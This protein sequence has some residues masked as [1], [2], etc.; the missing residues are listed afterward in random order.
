LTVFLLAPSSKDIFKF[1]YFKPTKEQIEESSKIDSIIRSK[2]AENSF[3]TFSR[4]SFGLSTQSAPYFFDFVHGYLLG[5]NRLD[6]EPYIRDFD[7]KKFSIIVGS[8]DYPVLKDA[9]DRNYY[10]YKI[11]G[12]TPLYLP[13]K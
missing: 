10:L 1:T 4:S 9:I 6:T 13:K 11:I 8:I 3:V 12:D 7:N 5:K 2:G